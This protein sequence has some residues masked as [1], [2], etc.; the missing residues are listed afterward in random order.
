MGSLYRRRGHAER[1]G[2]FL[3]GVIRLDFLRV[4]R[5]HALVVGEIAG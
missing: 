2:G 3:H 5:Q 4:L 1:Q